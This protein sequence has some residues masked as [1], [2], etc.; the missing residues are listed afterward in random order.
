M[1]VNSMAVYSLICKAQ[2]IPCCVHSCQRSSADTIE[3]SSNVSTNCLVITNLFTQLCDTALGTLH[4]VV[5]RLAAVTALQEAVLVTNKNLNTSRKTYRM[6][7]H[8]GLCSVVGA[9]VHG[10]SG[11]APANHFVIRSKG[12]AHS[13]S[14]T[15]PCQATAPKL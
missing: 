6:S 10:C 5:H 3:C 2:S 4:F 12:F 1:V 9:T 11:N 7:S 13:Y 8:T 15:R 14:S